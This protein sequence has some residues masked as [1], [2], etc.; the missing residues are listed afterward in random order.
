MYRGH[1]FG[2]DPS[3]YSKRLA[4]IVPYRDRAEHLKIFVPHML[5][6]FSQDKLDRHIDCSIHII[7]QSQRG[8]FNRGK[9]KNAGFHLASE[10]ADY[11][12]FH[13]VDYLPVWADYSWSPAPT[14]LIW[15]GLV[16]QEDWETFFGAVVMFDNAAFQKI[17]GY[18][19]CYWGWG[20]EDQE[21]G[22]RC[23]SLGVPVEK[24]DGTFSALSHPHAGISSPGVLTPEAQSTRATFLS[25]KDHISDL[26]KCDGLSQTEF[27]ISS[28][29]TIPVTGKINKNVMHYVI[30]I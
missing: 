16:L 6:Y 28:K 21:T 13:D 30:D 26:Q 11:V 22:M 24:R 1:P 17:N 7:E 4:I 9:I 14:R 23:K 5:A 20:F 2:I 3:A 18:P 12:C 27:M 29:E 25:R 19:N 8:A 15:N 10:K